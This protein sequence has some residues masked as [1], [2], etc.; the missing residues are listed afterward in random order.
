MTTPKLREILKA[1]VELLIVSDKFFAESS[2]FDA[3]LPLLTLLT[4]EIELQRIKANGGSP[5]TEDVERIGQQVHEIQANPIS[6]SLIYMA[7]QMGYLM[8]TQNKHLTKV[9]TDLDAFMKARRDATTL[10]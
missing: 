3:L 5:T 2:K 1:G 4:Q 9:V 7:V 8:A 10:Q 6:Y